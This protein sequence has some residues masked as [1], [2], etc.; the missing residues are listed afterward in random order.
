MYSSLRFSDFAAKRFHCEEVFPL[1]VSVD[2]Y[3]FA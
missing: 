3:F 2:N 1:S